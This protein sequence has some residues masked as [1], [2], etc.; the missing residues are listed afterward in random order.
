MPTVKLVKSRSLLEKS[1][2][3]IRRP[4]ISCYLHSSTFIGT[5]HYKYLRSLEL[6]KTWR[7]HISWAQK[8][9]WLQ[10]KRNSVIPKGNL[11]VWRKVSSFFSFSPL[12]SSCFLLGYM[13]NLSQLRL[14]LKSWDATVCVR[15]SWLEYPAV[16]P[17]YSA[18][19]SCLW[20]KMFLYIN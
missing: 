11:K 18:H 17:R 10:N 16:M 8:L 6:W 15:N 12:F 20:N 19:I 14:Q 13:T 4:T 9:Y 3:L 2:L 1:L 5:C 7:V